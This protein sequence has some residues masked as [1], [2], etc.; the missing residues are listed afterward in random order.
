LSDLLDDRIT[1]PAVEL[2]CLHTALFKLWLAFDAV[3]PGGHAATIVCAWNWL[4]TASAHRI[5]AEASAG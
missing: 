3:E 5:R 1:S 2:R 4:T